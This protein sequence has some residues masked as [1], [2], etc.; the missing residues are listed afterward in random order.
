MKY[1]NIKSVAHNIGHSFLSDMNA[2]MS[3]SRYT[4]VPELLF[5]ASEREHVREV[6]INLLTG[7]IQ[8]E[9]IALPEVQ[10]AVG[11]YVRGLAELLISQN[12]S[13]DAVTGAVLV[14]QF[15]YS[16]QRQARYQPE[17]LIPEFACEVEITD[18]RGEIHR[19]HP[20]NW[21]YE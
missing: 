1:K 8:P 7:E 19:G 16:R 11:H 15:D 3:G 21:W 12:V 6:R 18:D 20:N 4:I 9:S 17:V 14:I 5:R 10:E 13:L 2:V